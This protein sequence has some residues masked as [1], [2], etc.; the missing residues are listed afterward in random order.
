MANGKYIN[1]NYPF[2]NSDK[3]F[4][5]DLNDTD[6]A[7]IKAD[8]L[9]ILLTRRNQRLYNPNFG[10]DLLKFIFEPKD[11]QTLEE[12]KLEVETS[13]KAY[14]PNLSINGLTV[15]ESEDEEYLAIV[16]LNYTVTNN[17]FSTTDTVT[18]NI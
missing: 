7:A 2:K 4:F 17:V 10:T 5:L 14:L 9:H 12:L 18:I 8:L 16:T 1:I 13:I 11:G 3:G 15:T 6:S